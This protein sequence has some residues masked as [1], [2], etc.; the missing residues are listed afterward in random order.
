MTISI[1]NFLVTG[2]T[3]TSSNLVHVVQ[4]ETVNI[5]LAGVPFTTSLAFQNIDIANTW[6]GVYPS[7]ALNQV[8]SNTIEPVIIVENFDTQSMQYI[9]SP[10]G[11]IF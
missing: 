2:V 3:V 7:Y 8:V 6:L 1:D 5:V 9:I 4:N 11:T 10:I